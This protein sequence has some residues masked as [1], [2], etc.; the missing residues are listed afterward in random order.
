M[1]DIQYL[2][3]S[4][5]K[6]NKYIQQDFKFRHSPSNKQLSR[7]CINLKLIHF[8]NSD[9]TNTKTEFLTQIFN[10]RVYYHPS[11]LKYGARQ[12]PRPLKRRGIFIEKCERKTV[13]LPNV[14]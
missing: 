11:H 14:R 6:Y 8:K 13:N 12:V 9:K 10:R 5:L 3:I 4:H 7:E 2:G 1:C